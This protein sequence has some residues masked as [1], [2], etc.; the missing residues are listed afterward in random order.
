MSE[1]K[2]RYFDHAA[3]TAVDREVLEEMMPYF[4]IEYG[5]PSSLYSI[6]RSI[7]RAINKS[8]ERVAKAINCSEKEVYFT[9]CGSESDNIAL[10]GVAYE[11]K[12]KR[13]PYNYK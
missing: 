2:I 3:T 13:K 5:N 12:D 7:K 10:K 4:S 11:N 9:G 1:N 8:R 6:G